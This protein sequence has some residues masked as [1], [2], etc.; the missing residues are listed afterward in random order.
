M[1]KQLELE[2]DD[3]YRQ[4]EEGWISQKELNRL[5]RELHRDYAEDAR[6]RAEEAAQ[7]AYLNELER[8]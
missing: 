4:F 5:I 3:L 2:E 1:S 7:E 6:G 8:W